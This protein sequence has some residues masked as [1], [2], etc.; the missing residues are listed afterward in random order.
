MASKLLV[1]FSLI[2]ATIQLLKRSYQQRI[3][4]IP[5][6][7]TGSNASR[8]AIWDSIDA[9]HDEVILPLLWTL[10]NLGIPT[11]LYHDSF[12]PGS[13][14]ALAAWYKGEVFEYDSFL[15]E[16]MSQFHTIL[17]STGDLDTASLLEQDI[18]EQYP[19]LRVLTIA[20]YLINWDIRF[21]RHLE[22]LGKKKPAISSHALSKV[23]DYVQAKRWQFLVHSSH[24]AESLKVNYEL[25]S[26]HQL[27]ED[28][29]RELI[30]VFVPVMPVKRG[31]VG[32]DKSPKDFKACIVGRVNH[33]RAYSRI[34]AAMERAHKLNAANW[35]APKLAASKNGESAQSHQAT[36]VLSILG[37]SMRRKP[38]RVPRRL[39][40]MVRELD[41]VADGHIGYQ[42]FQQELQSADIVLPAFAKM[43]KKRYTTER[44]SG[45]I[46]AALMARVPVL[47]D[48][49]ELSAYSYLEPPAYV[50][51]KKGEDEI[52][53][54]ARLRAERAHHNFTVLDETA[55]WEKY[56]K[57]LYERNRQ[58]LQKALLRDS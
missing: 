17:L 14:Q 9:G 29:L 54:I 7:S 43:Q 40:G 1:A 8:I 6:A 46:P 57:K 5:P 52:H 23:A 19:H 37:R 16:D 55:A 15:S 47:V 50:L 49:V 25:Y 42:E 28:I 39:R 4:L 30:H 3:S 41:D 32:T 31:Q 44:A 36:F 33:L 38:Y 2:I 10:Q 11:S 27:E 35:R 26:G 45:S 18:L 20:H 48:D 22:F 56:E 21:A 58:F 51:R 12:R 13:R 53:A 34:I 24:V